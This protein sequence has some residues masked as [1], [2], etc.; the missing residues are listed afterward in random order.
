MKRFEELRDEFA[1]VYDGTTCS[2][3]KVNAWKDGADWAHAE[4]KTRMDVAVKTLEY[5]AESVPFGR[6]AREAL[7][8]L[9]KADEIRGW[10]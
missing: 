2:S 8:A 9:A 7:E 5:Y 3:A 1:P 4:F 6:E 10:E